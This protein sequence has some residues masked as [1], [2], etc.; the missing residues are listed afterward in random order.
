MLSCWSENS[1]QRPSFTKLRAT[2]DTM[3]LAEGK[4]DYLDF[5]FD[6]S[7]TKPFIQ[8][9]DGET[10]L[11][12]TSSLHFLNVSPVAEHCSRSHSSE[13][14][15]N[16]F[17][18]LLNTDGNNGGCTLVSSSS[19][20]SL[21]LGYEPTSPRQR[22]PIDHNH[23]SPRHQPSGNHTQ[24]LLA[25]SGQQSLKQHSPM[26][27]FPSLQSADSQLAH[28]RLSFTASGNLLGEE[29]GDVSRCSE[30]PRPM[31]LLLS[32]ERDRRKENV[33]DRYVKEPTKFANLNPMAE[34]NI[35]I[36]GGIGG[37]RGGAE[38]GRISEAGGG[39]EG[40][41]I[42]EAGGGTE[43][44]RISE[45]GGGVEEGRISEAGRGGSA[46]EDR[47]KSMRL[48]QSR[49]DAEHCILRR[50]SDGALNMNSN[51]YVSFVEVFSA[52]DGQVDHLQIPVTEDM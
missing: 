41:R 51:G 30:R 50:G 8:I 29:L 46:E 39:A 18:L 42:S 34:S 38:G 26:R 48:T 9:Q 15:E 45:A 17:K 12:T 52:K 16:T 44:G 6:V 4:G 10:S 22:S 3:L 24:Q 40:G 27:L 43:G 47:R 14:L 36:G 13:L 21:N 37:V 2:F 11:S 20:P 19:D 5:S 1:H 32:R 25:S 49:T 23:V 33:S 7:S 28:S 35:F 31:S